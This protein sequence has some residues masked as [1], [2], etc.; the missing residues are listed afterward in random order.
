MEAFQGEGICSG[1]WEMVGHGLLLLC[2]ALN[3]TL[4]SREK[5]C[6]ALNLRATLEPI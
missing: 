5:F 6:F 3:Q 1:L 2:T 4:T